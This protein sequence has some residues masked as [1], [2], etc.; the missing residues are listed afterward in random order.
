[1][2]DRGLAEALDS[3][4]DSLQQL[5][6]AITRSSPS[7]NPSGSSEGWVLVGPETPVEPG[8]GARTCAPFSAHSW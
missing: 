8:S 1:M 4:A 7:A 5:S 2:S 6:L 3:L